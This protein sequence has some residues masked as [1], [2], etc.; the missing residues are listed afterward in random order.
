MSPPGRNVSNKVWGRAEDN[1]KK[2]QKIKV[3]RPKQKQC[4]V[5]DVSVDES[6]V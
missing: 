4:S 6:K 2:L 1:Y 5:M 3:A